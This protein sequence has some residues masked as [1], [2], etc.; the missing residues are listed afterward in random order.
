MSVPHPKP[1]RGSR[2]AGRMGVFE[3]PACGHRFEAL[4]EPAQDGE[5]SL[6]HDDDAAC[7]ACG[8]GDCTLVEV[9]A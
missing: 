3:C 4:V 2:S 7:P 5:W 8:S 1:A 9:E 6:L